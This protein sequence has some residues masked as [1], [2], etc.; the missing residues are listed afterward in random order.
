MPIE[1][2]IVKQDKEQGANCASLV[3]FEWRETRPTRGKN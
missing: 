2:E 1:A 3:Q